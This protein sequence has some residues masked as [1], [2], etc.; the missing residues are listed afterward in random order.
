MLWA[1][2]MCNDEDRK[3]DKFLTIFTF[4]IQDHWGVSQTLHNTRM[5]MEFFLNDKK[6]SVIT[7]KGLEPATQPPLVS[8]TRMLPEHQ[9]DT[10][11]RQDL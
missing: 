6:K 1:L 4:G 8:E 9:Q 2:L 11:E 10:Y 7:L 5:P 3:S